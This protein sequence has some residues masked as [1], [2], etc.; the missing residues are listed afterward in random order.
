M[1]TGVFVLLVVL[2]GMV[3]FAVDVGYMVDVRTELQRSAD[4]CAMAAVNRL[5]D[6]SLAT[7]IAEYFRDQGK[8]VLLLM[9]IKFQT[10][11][12]INIHGQE[13]VR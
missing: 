11:M 3:A 5:P 13:K 2:F 12:S 4:A 8:Q 9:L 7:S 10:L 6:A 1:A